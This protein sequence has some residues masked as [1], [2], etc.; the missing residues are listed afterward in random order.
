MA[1]TLENL[2]LTFEKSIHLFWMEIVI[3]STQVGVRWINGLLTLVFWGHA[4]PYTGFM[5]A[6]LGEQF[7]Q[8]SNTLATFFFFC[9]NLIFQGSLC[10]K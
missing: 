3:N 9:I 1:N 7:L 4:L 6:V 10:M 8:T 5:G 2:L